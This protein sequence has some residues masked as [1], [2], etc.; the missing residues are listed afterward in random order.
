MVPFVFTVQSP[1]SP[2][3]NDLSQS[4]LADADRDTF[5]G[6]HGQSFLQLFDDLY[7]NGLTLLFWL[8]PDNPKDIERLA[9]T[10]YLR[11]DPGRSRFLHARFAHPFCAAVKVLFRF[12]VS[13]DAYIRIS[14]LLRR[15]ADLVVE[16]SF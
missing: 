7:N 12:P 11:P 5:R 8:S 16:D 2:G 14:M 9:R 4:I 15:I 6:P 3:W 10:D 13:G 1:V